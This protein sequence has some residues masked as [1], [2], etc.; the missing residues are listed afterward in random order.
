MQELYSYNY[1]NFRTFSSSQKETL[2]TFPIVSQPVHSVSLRQ[3]HTNFMSL[4]L[5]FLDI[6]CKLDH[7]ICGSLWL[8]S[9]I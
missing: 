3:A 1:I 6:S 7:K 9:F 4:D 8:T 5:L 2:Y